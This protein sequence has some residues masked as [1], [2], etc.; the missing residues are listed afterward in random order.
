M[1]KELKV[2]FKVVLIL[3]AAA[4]A[5]QSFL[6]TSPYAH[7][8]PP[9]SSFPFHPIN[10]IRE[11]WSV[12]TLHV[13]YRTDQIAR[14]R[15]QDLRDHQNRRLYRRAH[16]MEDMDVEEDQG[17]DIRN[18]VEWDDGLT[19]IERKRGGRIGELFNQNQ[20]KVEGR[21]GE[22][23]EEFGKRKAEEAREE[24]RRVRKENRRRERLEAKRREREEA[25]R[26]EREEAQRR[27][28]ERK[29]RR[30]W[31]LGIW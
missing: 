12:Y 20:W 31:G 30:W 10:F 26:L 1:R 6:H 13:A 16:G 15:H 21:E 2:S 25:G 8:L 24:R 9:L 7:L 4:S 18:L 28:A 5:Y 11:T 22:S 23:F 14:T 19:N 29:S 3:L 27:E 17:L